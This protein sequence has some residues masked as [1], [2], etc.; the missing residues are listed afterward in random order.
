MPTW[1]WA[2]CAIIAA[3]FA[4]SLLYS[5]AEEGPIPFALAL[6]FIVLDCWL[7]SQVIG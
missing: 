4:L 2:A 3:M 6:A 1:L 7:W 5:S